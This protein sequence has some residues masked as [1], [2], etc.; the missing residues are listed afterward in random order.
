LMVRDICDRFAAT[1][2]DCRLLCLSVTVFYFD[3]DD[4]R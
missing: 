3:P 2:I 1:T 4:A